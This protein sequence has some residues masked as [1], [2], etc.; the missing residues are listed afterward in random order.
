MTNLLLTNEEI[1]SAQIGLA[2]AGG[3]ER[4]ICRAQ[5]RKLVKILKKDTVDGAFGISEELWETLNKEK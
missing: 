4:R 2:K 1:L 3:N 5:L